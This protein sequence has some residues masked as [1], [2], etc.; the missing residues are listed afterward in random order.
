VAL[1]HGDAVRAARAL[2]RRRAWTAPWCAWCPATSPRRWTWRCCPSWC[3][4]PSASAQAAAPHPR[5][6]AG[7]ARF[8]GPS[9]QRRAEEVPVAEYG[10]ARSVGEEVERS[11]ERSAAFALNAPARPPLPA[12]SLR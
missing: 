9:T 12:S 2:T 6:L 8:A 3:R 10:L 4:W 1:R 5:A 7:G 11:A